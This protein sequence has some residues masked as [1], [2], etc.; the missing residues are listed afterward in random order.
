MRA[1]VGQDQIRL[2]VLQNISTV[3]QKEINRGA[4]KYLLIGCGEIIDII[5]MFDILRAW[6][7]NE[8]QRNIVRQVQRAIT[9]CFSHLFARFSSCM[10]LSWR[11][12][13]NYVIRRRKSD[14]VGEGKFEWKRKM[15]L[16]LGS[17]RGCVMFCELKGS[18]GEEESKKVSKNHRAMK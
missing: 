11:E 14:K 18:G 1:K 17:F 10:W 15:T 16:R 5:L 6:R 12:T 3:L 8:T 9:S 2:P 13:G 4:I 7:L